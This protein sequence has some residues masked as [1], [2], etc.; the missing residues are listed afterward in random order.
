MLTFLST[1]LFD[2]FISVVF[3]SFRKEQ[4][5]CMVLTINNDQLFSFQFTTIKTIQQLKFLSFSQNDQTQHIFF[6]LKIT[7][8]QKESKKEFI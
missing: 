2:L 1:S 8:V 6:L 4:G 3:G 7:F 5:C